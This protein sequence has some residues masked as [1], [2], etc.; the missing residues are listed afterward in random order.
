MAALEGSEEGFMVMAD[1][2]Y[3]VRSIETRLYSN[4]PS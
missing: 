3:L 2:L 1:P 4:M